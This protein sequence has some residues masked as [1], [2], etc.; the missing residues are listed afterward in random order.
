MYKLTTPIF[1]KAIIVKIL[2]LIMIISI[3][4]G[5]E[6]QKT[7]TLPSENSINKFHYQKDN[8]LET[9]EKQSETNTNETLLEAPEKQTKIN[10]IIDQ[11]KS[12]QVNESTLT[13]QS[14]DPLLITNSS[15]NSNNDLYQVQLNDLDNQQKTTSP[16]E[17]L[18]LIFLYSDY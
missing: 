5:C 13:K 16:T 1:Y 8:L 10:T 6:N 7:N 9:E 3:I 12:T 17:N 14:A 4:T 18:T 2:L 11:N 15:N